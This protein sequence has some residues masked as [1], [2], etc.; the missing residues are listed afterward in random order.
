M[1]RYYKSGGGIGCGTRQW[2]PD[3]GLLSLSLSL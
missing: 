1:G 3:S 2:F